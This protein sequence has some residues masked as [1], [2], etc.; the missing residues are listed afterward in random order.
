LAGGIA[1]PSDWIRADP[2]GAVGVVLVVVLP[3]DPVPPVW[4]A[5]GTAPASEATNSSPANA[6]FLLLLLVSDR[7]PFSFVGLRG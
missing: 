4:A 7:K 3:G 5:A 2:L 6:S 1:V